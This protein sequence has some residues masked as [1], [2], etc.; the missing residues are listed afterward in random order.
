MWYRYIHSHYG[1]WCLIYYI[2]HVLYLI[3]NDKYWMNCFFYW[4]CYFHKNIFWSF[5]DHIVWFILWQHLCSLLLGSL[6]PII[7]KEAKDTWGIFHF[8]LLPSDH[9]LVQRRSLMNFPIWVTTNIIVS[10]LAGWD[11]RQNFK[12]N[13]LIKGHSIKL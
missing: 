3:L 4:Q 5:L 2:I 6:S 1:E 9:K 10:W 13:H 8:S 7:L 12:S 11:A